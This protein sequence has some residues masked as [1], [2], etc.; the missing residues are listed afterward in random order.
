MFK[1]RLWTTISRTGV[2]GPVVSSPKIFTRNYTMSAVPT[3]TESWLS[4]PQSTQFYT[5]TYTPPSPPRAL[6]VA[7]HGF[8]E[9]IGRYS[10]F[11]PLFL[12]YNIAVFALDQRGFGMTAQD[13]QGKK[14]KNSAYG[15]TSWKEQMDDIDWALTHARKAFSGIP[16]FLMGHSMGGGEVLGFVTQGVNSPHQTTVSSLAGVIATSPL[17]TQTKPAPKLLR[18]VGG[19]ASSFAPHTLIPATVVAHD[20]SR[21]PAS[22]E[23]YLKDPLVKQSG[24]LRGLHDMLTH[25]EIL[26]NA[27]YKEWPAALPVLLVHGT[28]DKVT[29]H[30][31]T[32]LFYDKITAHSKKLKLFEGGFHELQNEPE[33]VKENLANEIVTFVEAQLTNH[34]VPVASNQRSKM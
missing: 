21:D 16:I 30:I 7:I 25:G 11:H 29:S 4:G 32:Q 23:A 27:Y 10:H 3:Y 13:R 8:A 24:S 6:L 12:Q 9:H 5:R 31:A 14:S 28:E 22:N 26:L 20:L 2:Q 1:T 17:I 33:R 19:K 18:W 15:K 34:E